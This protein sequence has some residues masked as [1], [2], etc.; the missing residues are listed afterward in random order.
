MKRITS[1]LVLQVET[2]G[3]KHLQDKIQIDGVRIDGG[4]YEGS[5]ALAMPAGKLKFKKNKAAEPV[6]RILSRKQ[7]KRL[8][9]IVDVKKKK[10]DRAELLEK[11]A[12]VQVDQSTLSGPVSYSIRPNSVLQY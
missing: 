2:E 3:V 10:G 4:G 6:G 12:Q 11:L 1:I 7:R 5:N 9:H 8:E